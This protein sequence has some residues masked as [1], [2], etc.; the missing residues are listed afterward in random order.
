MCIIRATG[1]RTAATKLCG[2]VGRASLTEKAACSCRLRTHAEITGEWQ[3]SSPRVTPFA[4]SAE[5]ELNARVDR[6]NAAARP[7]SSPP[8]ASPRASRPTVDRAMGLARAC[9]KG[10]GPTLNI[11]SLPRKCSQVAKHRSTC[12]LRSWWVR[13]QL[14]GGS[15]RRQDVATKDIDQAAILVGA[16]LVRESCHRR[17]RQAT[18]LCSQR[19]RRLR[20][21]RSRKGRAV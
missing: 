11:Y 5:L 20:P 7:P 16:N 19:T 8:H 6:K 2:L 3:R 13:T 12:V 14:D 4:R 9:G 10:A 1:A 18:V 15:S 17:V 21:R